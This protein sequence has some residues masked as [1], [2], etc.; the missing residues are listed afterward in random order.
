MMGLDYIIG[1]TIKNEE[2]DSAKQI[3]GQWQQENRTLIEY[4]FYLSK[5]WTN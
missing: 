5:D 2:S 4:P 1:D 3:Q